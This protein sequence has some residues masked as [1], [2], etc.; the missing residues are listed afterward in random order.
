MN[1]HQSHLELRL[2]QSSLNSPTQQII[3]VLSLVTQLALIIYTVSRF[4]LLHAV[5]F[6]FLFTFHFIT[7]LIN[8]HRT[9]PFP[10]ILSKRSKLLLGV[11]LN[12]TETVN[13]LWL[14]SKNYTPTFHFFTS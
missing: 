14:L 8:N 3:L 9:V 7:P 6:I 4:S 12:V 2:I 11:Y 1:L 10:I 5:S 13:I